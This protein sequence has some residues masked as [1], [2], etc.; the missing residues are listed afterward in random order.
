MSNVRP[1]CLLAA[2]RH[3][4]NRDRWERLM[5]ATRRLTAAQ[6]AHRAAAAAAPVRRVV[7]GACNQGN[8]AIL[9]E[10]LAAFRSAVRDASG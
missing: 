8:L 9:G 10:L 3:R 1:L 5:H 7:E 6:R 4:Y 2:D